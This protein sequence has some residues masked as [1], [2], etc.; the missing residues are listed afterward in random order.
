MASQ[1]H[2]Y[3]PSFVRS[4][5]AAGLMLTSLGLSGTTAAA[6]LF[7]PMAGAWKGDGSI[8]WNTGE[9]ERLRCTAK[10]A[11]ERDGNRINQSLTC[12]TDST[13][14]IV[15]SNIT[16]NPDAGAITGT[17]SET[18]Y[19]INGVVS[20]TANANAVKALVQSTDHRFSA[21]VTVATK[22]ANQ[23]VTI[24]PTGIDVE[25]VAVQLK[26]GGAADD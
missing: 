5:A 3:V 12:A 10:Y 7:D 17:W 21:R 9:T 26:R 16:Y 23:T 8:A 6:G 18:T 15:K 25:N 13:R 2:R 24:A 11:V 14:L 22:G 19:G 4:A 1:M 20:G